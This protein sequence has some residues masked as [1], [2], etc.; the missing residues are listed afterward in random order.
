VV[1]VLAKAATI[2]EALLATG[3]AKAVLADFAGG[4]SL[5]VARWLVLVYFRNAGRQPSVFAAPASFFTCDH[6]W[7]TLAFRAALCGG[8]A[9]KQRQTEEKGRDEQKS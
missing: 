1:D 4:A 8:F 2:G 5:G 3:D 9:D 7:L 6:T